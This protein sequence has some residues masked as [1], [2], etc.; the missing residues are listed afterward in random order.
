MT[1]EH[2]QMLLMTGTE[3][4]MHAAYDWGRDE[5][6]KLEDRVWD[7]LQSQG[8]ERWFH[9]RLVFDSGLQ[10]TAHVKHSIR[11]YAQKPSPRKILD[12]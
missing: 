7:E 1:K 8:N 4:P 12:S 10:N 5:V 2:L 9:T 6:A 3:G 11:C